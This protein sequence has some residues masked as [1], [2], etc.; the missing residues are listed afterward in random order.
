MTAIAEAQALN[1]EE[2]ERLT[3]RIEIKLDTLAD[4]YEA[5][6]PLI[7]EAIDRRA[8][9]ALG[10]QTFSAYAAER[11]REHL[12]RL[13]VDVRRAVERELREAGL[14]LKAIAP[15]VGVSYAQ[16]S[17]DTSDQG[18]HDVNPEPIARVT[19]TVKTE[20]YIDTETGEVITPPEPR[21]I[22]GL[23]GKEYTHRLKAAPTVIINEDEQREIERRA[24]LEL[25]VR[26]SNLDIAEAVYTLAEYD[27]DR[28]ISEKFSRHAEFVQP[29]IRITPDRLSAAIDFL[30][31]LQKEISK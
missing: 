27:T 21:K 18:L 22:G 7:R 30:T 19:E 4:A 6:M 2:A 24:A 8:H 12:V 23:D 13:D 1:Q 17:R 20:T 29:G 15:I 10:Y 25:G 5:V 14:S 26:T 31:R 3:Q 28:F 11:F 9:E 16:V